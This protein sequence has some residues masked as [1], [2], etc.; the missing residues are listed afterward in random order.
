[1]A[2]AKKTVE[3]PP[4]VNE[5][6]GSPVRKTVLTFTKIKLFKGGSLVLSYKKIDKDGAM[7]DHDGE[8]CDR[9]VH[10]DLINKMQEGA[11]HY[12]LRCG[13]LSNQQIKDLDKYSPE[14]IKDFH[15]TGVTIKEE[16]YAILHGYKQLKTGEVVLA[17]AP[18]T[19]FESSEEKAYRYVD[20]LQSWIEELKAE[21]ILYLDG[22]A[23]EKPQ[24]ELQFP[25]KEEE[26]ELEEA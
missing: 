20:E 3:G 5:N 21:A 4:L 6:N 22:K 18:R 9:I 11:V 25:E 10:A 24:Q 17:N 19:F 14:L 23:G 16:E 8:K 7:S 2:K 12:A 15:M 26:K 1:M 13:Y